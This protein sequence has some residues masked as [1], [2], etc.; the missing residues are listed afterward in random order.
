MDTV[1]IS[2]VESG[3]SAVLL[4]LVLWVFLPRVVTS[5]DA[6]TERNTREH[7]AIT[8]TLAH[9]MSRLSWHEAKVHGIDSVVSDSHDPQ[10]RAAI[11]AF[12]DS[13][14]ETAHLEQTI[15]DLFNPKDTK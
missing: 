6:L 3:V 14:A 11:E 13:Q 4:A 12:R 1:M 8:V 7:M 15:R 10:M 5:L 9:F 2:L